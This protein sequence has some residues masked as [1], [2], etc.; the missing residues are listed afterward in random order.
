MKIIGSSR[1]LI[2]FL[3]LPP[4]I[5]IAQERPEIYVES[6]STD[7]L[8][9]QKHNFE[10]NATQNEYTKPVRRWNGTGYK[11]VLTR[12][13]GGAKDFQ[14]E[15]WVVEL[16]EVL[17]KEGKKEELGCNLLT[18]EGCGSGGDNISDA[19]SGI[20]FPR[21]NPTKID[22]VLR[23][24]YYPLFV[25]RVIKVKSFYVV[26]EVTSYK[27]NVNNPK[28]LDSM[29]VTVEFKNTHHRPLDS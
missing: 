1:C 23:G 10:L 6:W 7:H 28:K 4:A 13:P 2:L 9:E 15:Y 16:R 21:E 29:S 11:L 5:C 3:F 24:N 25:K 17:S 27:M 18:T 22:L 12:I 20:L 14:I 26:I 8:R 19:R